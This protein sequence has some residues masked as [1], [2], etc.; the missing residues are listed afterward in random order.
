M[1]PAVLVFPFSTIV[2]QWQRE[3]ERRE[4]G[5]GLRKIEMREMKEEK[6]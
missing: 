2:H 4:R 3:N 5:K 6:S 1:N